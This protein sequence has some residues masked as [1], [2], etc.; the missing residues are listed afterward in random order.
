MV[1][2]DANIDVTTIP[3][4]LKQFNVKAF[5]TLLLITTSDGFTDAALYNK[6]TYEDYLTRLLKR[7]SFNKTNEKKIAEHLVNCAG[8]ISDDDITVS[9]QA[10]VKQNKRTDFNGL[11]GIYDGHGGNAA[12]T[13]VAENVPLVLNELLTLS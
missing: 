8:L 9:I 13:F 6:N 3:S 12:A 11:L 5:G 1:I 7:M 2:A 10:I 4:L